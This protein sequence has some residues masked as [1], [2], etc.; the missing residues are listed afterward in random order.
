[1]TAADDESWEARFVALFPAYL[2]P[3][4]VHGSI[5][6]DVAE[7]LV[8]RVMGPGAAFA[9]FRSAAFIGACRGELASFVTRELPDLCQS[10]RGRTQVLPEAHRGRLV[11]RLDVKRTLASRMRGD[12]ELLTSR[13]RTRR[14]DHPAEVVVR[15]VAV[16]LLTVFASLRRA[17][18]RTAPDWASSVFE[19]EVG[20][21]HSVDRTAMRR[22]DDVPFAALDP[23]V[24]P[25]QR[26]PAFALAATL[27]R[28]LHE[29]LDANDPGRI[30]QWVSRGSLW[31]LERWQRFELAVALTLAQRIE[32]RLRRDEPGRWS[33]QHAVIDSHRDDI[34]AFGCDDGRRLRVYYNQSPLASGVR[35][36]A[37]AH[38]FGNVGT[39]RPDVVV[40]G[41]CPGH[42]L[43]AVVVE[44]KLSDDPGYLHDGYDEALVY[45]FDYAQHLVS[46]SGSVLVTKSAQRG[47]PRPADQVVVLGWPDW[48]RPNVVLDAVM[49]TVSG[50]D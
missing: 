39:S 10:L 50:A 22:V 36:E 30:A 42:R 17:W 15:A 24:L 6:R 27:Y 35:Q 11:G 1:M 38:Y 2:L 14:F 7:T 49:A 25:G 16:R 3:S 48:Q 45:A 26:H 32:D 43:R 18:G 21:R 40:V 23:R 44:V 5:D 46:Q 19:W 31:P 4:A 29:T 37:V 12:R 8:R 34:V 41:E 9:T 28:A 47:K 13:V 33:V 20:L